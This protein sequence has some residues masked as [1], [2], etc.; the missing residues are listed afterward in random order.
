MFSDFMKAFENYEKL[1]G[2]VEI[3]KKECQ[4]CGGQGWIECCP[5]S[6]PVMW[7]EI[8]ACSACQEWSIDACESCN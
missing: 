5:G 7:P 3:E 2:K 1:F 8:P 6:G 4:D